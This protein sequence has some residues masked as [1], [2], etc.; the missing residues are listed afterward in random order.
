M[1][2][3]ASAQPPGK[4]RRIPG[5]VRIDPLNSRPSPPVFQWRSSPS[6]RR[7]HRW[8]TLRSARRLTA[9]CA[10]CNVKAGRSVRPGDV[11]FRA[12]RKALAARTPQ[13]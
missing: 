3:N 1:E 4:V 10:G 9:G 2:S 5:T 13:P 12:Q 6:A 8:H 11:I 7:P